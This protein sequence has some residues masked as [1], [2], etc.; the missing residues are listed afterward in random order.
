MKHGII[1]LLVSCFV[2]LTSLSECESNNLVHH[3]VENPVSVTIDGIVY[4]SQPEKILKI[5]GDAHY[6]LEDA[7][8]F[9]FRIA[10]TISSAEKSYT[11]YLNVESNEPFEVGKRYDC[12]LESSSI[13]SI[14]DDGGKWTYHDAVTGWIE[15]TDFSK[16]NH[17]YV[18]GNFEMDVEDY[19]E[20]PI[21][22]RNGRFSVRIYYDKNE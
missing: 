10:R 5:G 19:D 1:P 2:I 15:F 13:M 21:E 12:F 11:L 8:G 22:L 16:G 4:E 17:Y 18:S 7:G 3:T 14:S 9:T 20:S 6:L